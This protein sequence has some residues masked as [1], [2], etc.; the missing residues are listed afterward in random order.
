M[1]KL[2]SNSGTR[3]QFDGPGNKN[4]NRYAQANV[5]TIG[6]SWVLYVPLSIDISHADGMIVVV[7]DGGWCCCRSASPTLCWRSRDVR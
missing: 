3:S 4:G 1:M 7:V 5:T 6:I 2:V